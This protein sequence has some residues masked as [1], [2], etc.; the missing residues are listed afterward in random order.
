MGNSTRMALTPR[1]S[2]LCRC[3]SLSADPSLPSPPLHSPV[4]S[5]RHPVVVRLMAHNSALPPMPVGAAANSLEAMMAKKAQASRVEWT[6]RRRSRQQIDD[7]VT[8][9]S[10]AHSF[11][12]HSVA[13]SA[14]AFAVSVFSWT[15]TCAPWRS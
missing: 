7:T 12:W 1:C 11:A 4:H 2:V 13:A 3:S 6:T 9:K 15:R 10:D 14:G 8:A 5:D